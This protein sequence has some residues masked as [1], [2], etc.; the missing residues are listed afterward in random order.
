MPMT[1]EE[2]REYDKNYRE[3][4]KERLKEQ[5]KKWN[6]ANKEKIKEQHKK[7]RE[8]NK[9][10][11]DLLHNIWKHKNK[12][13]IKEYKK[14]GNGKKI[15]TISAW[16]KKLKIKFDDKKEAEFYYE[17]YINATN[18]SWCDKKFKSNNDRH[19]DHCHTCNLPRAIICCYCNTRDLVP[20]VNCLL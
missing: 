20:C 14:M 16:V 4:N 18:C 19:L 6:E 12:E 5:K 17:T 3:A 1:K 13:K 9:D 10:N 7:Y 15:D 11:M 2:R 8:N